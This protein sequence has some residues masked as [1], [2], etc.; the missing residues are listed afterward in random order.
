M[1]IVIEICEKQNY[2]TYLYHAGPSA[3][4]VDLS[5][6]P[7]QGQADAASLVRRLLGGPRGRRARL[8]RE[9]GTPG[10]FV[11]NIISDKVI[12]GHI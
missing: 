7:H 1:N 11:E 9:L 3:Y 4:L 6:T 10:V 12:N 5:R 2:W 8:T